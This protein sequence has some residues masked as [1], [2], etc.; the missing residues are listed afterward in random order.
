MSDGGMATPKGAEPWP[1]TQLICDLAKVSLARRRAA[2]PET[3]AAKYGVP[4]E[5]A[6]FYIAESIRCEETWPIKG[7]QS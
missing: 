4:V 2:V 1:L 5:W 7:E 3:V 6:R